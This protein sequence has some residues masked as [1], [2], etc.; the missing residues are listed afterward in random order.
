MKHTQRK[1]RVI[2]N[3]SSKTNIDKS[4]VIDIHCLQINNLK[5]KFILISLSVLLALGF[6]CRTR[7]PKAKADKNPKTLII[8]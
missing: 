5:L 3:L 2:T 6:S 8:S 1:I 7:K 4:H